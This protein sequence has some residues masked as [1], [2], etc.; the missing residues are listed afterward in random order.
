MKF[1]I[2]AFAAAFLAGCT[3]HPRQTIASVRAAGVSERTVAKLDHHGVLV[4]NDL[5]ELKRRGVPDSVPIRHLDKVGVDYVAQRDDFRR[6]RSAGVRPAV[7]DA[8]ADASREFVRGRYAPPSYFAAGFDAP[9]HYGGRWWWPYA[10]V[11][12]GYSWGH[13]RCR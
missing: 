1:A 3:T 13:W 11:S 10:D 4:P 6:L 2:L 5:I 7:S 8:L 9:W 12:L